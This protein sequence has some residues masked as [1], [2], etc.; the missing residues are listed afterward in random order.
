MDSTISKTFLKTD[1]HVRVW[2][3]NVNKVTDAEGT[4]NYR[5]QKASLIL[6]DEIMSTFLRLKRKS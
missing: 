3:D 2:N 4:L 5:L 1:N 6:G